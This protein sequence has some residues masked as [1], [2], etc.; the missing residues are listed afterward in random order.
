MSLAA[1]ASQHSPQHQSLLTQ[2]HQG[3]HVAGGS[4]DIQD[5]LKAWK[6]WAGTRKRGKMAQFIVQKLEECVCYEVAIL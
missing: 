6:S 5:W 3:N 4:A 2:H 1:Y